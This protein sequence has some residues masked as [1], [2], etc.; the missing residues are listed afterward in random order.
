MEKILVKTGIYSFIVSFFLLV[1]FK[2]REIS[3]IDEEGWTSYTEIPYSEYFFTIFRYSVIISLFAVLFMLLY[4]F[5]NKT[6][7]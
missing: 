6:K 5:A 4:I 7:S 2:K 1:I 3:D